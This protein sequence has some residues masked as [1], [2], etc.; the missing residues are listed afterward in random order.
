[1]SGNPRVTQAQVRMT[2]GFIDQD[3]TD[4]VLIPTTRVTTPA[5]GFD[6]ADGTPRDVQT[7]KLILLAYD[8]RPTLTL[9]GVERVI[10][11]HILGLPDAI[12]AVG[13]YW[14]DEEGTR[15]DIVG[16]SEGW[17]YETKAFASRHVPRSARP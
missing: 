16:M 15:W 3:P 14:V 4:V 2:Q 12:I 17:N 9:A 11:Y 1:M 10:D 6:E 5:G 8:Q 13:D 7:F